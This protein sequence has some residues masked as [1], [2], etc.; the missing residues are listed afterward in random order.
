MLTKLLIGLIISL[1][2]FSSYKTTEPI[3]EEPAT[4]SVFS[5]DTSEAEL[6]ECA[7]TRLSFDESEPATEMMSFYRFSDEN[8]TLFGLVD[9]NGALV[10]PPVYDWAEDSSEGYSVVYIDAEHSDKEYYDVFGNLIENDISVCTYVNLKGEECFGY[11][12]DALRFSEGV[13]FVK[14]VNKNWHAMNK[15]GEIIHSFD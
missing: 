8:S 5:Q 13:A 6:S 2:I 7:Y 12:S 9:T 4:L 14:D 1:T 15:N 3:I 11:Y 10:C